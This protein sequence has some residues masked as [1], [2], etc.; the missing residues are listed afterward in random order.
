[1]WQRRAELRLRP[2]SARAGIPS[3]ITNSKN[4]DKCQLA[5]CVCYHCT[6]NLLARTYKLT[7]MYAYVHTYLHT[8][9]HT[10]FVP[11]AS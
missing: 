1:M 10:R 7:H 3:T 2:G 9:M 8:C 6:I 5:V 4:I 11:A